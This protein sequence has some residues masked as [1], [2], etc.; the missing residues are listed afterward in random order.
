MFLCLDH[1][2][3]LWLAHAHG[4]CHLGARTAACNVLQD[5]PDEI[6]PG[7]WIKTSS[8]VLTPCA[9]PCIDATRQTHIQPDTTRTHAVLE[10]FQV[11]L[12]PQNPCDRNKIDPEPVLS[13]GRAQA[14]AY[15][16]YGQHQGNSSSKYASQPQQ[17]V[18]PLQHTSGL[19]AQYGIASS[20]ERTSRNAYIA[21]SR[22]IR[23]LRDVL[24][25]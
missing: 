16:Q 6:A 14:V 7:I 20:V 24:T 15:S 11:L 9:P 4:A 5:T 23:P 3:V 21:T 13:I 22:L 2:S 17:S 25:Y 8:V 18:D 19:P 1:V 10:N 12:H